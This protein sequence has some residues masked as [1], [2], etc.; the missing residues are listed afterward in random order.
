MLVDTGAV[1]S[2]SEEL[3]SDVA[4]LVMKTDK[5]QVEELAPETP[6]EVPEESLRRDVLRP[7]VQDLEN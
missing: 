4:K 5:A 1:S 7:S 3:N 2:S 6:T